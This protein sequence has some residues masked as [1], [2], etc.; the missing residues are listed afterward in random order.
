MWKITCLKSLKYFYLIE[1]SFAKTH[2]FANQKLVCLSPSISLTSKRKILGSCPRTQC[3]LVVLLLLYV[4]P[5]THTCIHI[6][7]LNTSLM[8]LLSTREK[9]IIRRHLSRIQVVRKQRLLLFF[10]QKW[11]EWR[12]RSCF[13]C[14]RQGSKQNSRVMIFIVNSIERI[15]FHTWEKVFLVK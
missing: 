7:P 11:K 3:L 9:R 6:C 13:R 15:H 1:N 4:R 5:H 14:S 12:I 10:T 8:S 2:C